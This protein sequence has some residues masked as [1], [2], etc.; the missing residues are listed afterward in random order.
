MTDW[1]GDDGWL[2]RCYAEYRNF[3][4]LSDVIRIRGTV[5]DKFVDE[6]GS[7]VVRLKTSAMNQRGA[8]VMPGESEIVLPSRTE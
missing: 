2:R 5:T 7:H 6:D 4:F 1:M 8:D 3:V